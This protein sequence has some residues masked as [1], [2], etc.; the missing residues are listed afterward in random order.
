[1]K[2]KITTLILLLV[3]FLLNAY[4][5][6]YSVYSGNLDW[7]ALCRVIKDDDSPSEVESIYE[8]YISGDLTPYEKARAEY[9]MVRYYM[10]RKENDKAEEHYKKQEDAVSSIKDDD[11]SVVAS[12]SR[13]E[14][15]SSSYYISKDIFT[16][17]SNS[18]TLKKLYSEHPDEIY[19]IL[20]NAWRLIYTPYI[21]GGSS[22]KAASLLTPLLDITSTLSEENRYSLYGALA[23]A[24]Y[25]MHDYSEAEEYLDEALAI[26]S[27]EQALLELKEKLSKK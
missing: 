25:N 10:D 18:S 21:A 13:Y 2:R 4:I 12:I 23:T 5:D 9:N 15:L 27:G 11:E 14:L 17:M 3:P 8:K 7:A 26:Y 1:M 22:K 6:S 20:N 16:G 24:Y 19:L